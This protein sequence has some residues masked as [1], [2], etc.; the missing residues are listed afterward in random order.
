MNKIPIIWYFIIR[1]SLLNLY[2]DLKI[3]VF[4]SD[5]MFYFILENIEIIKLVFIV[6]GAL[7]VVYNFYIKRDRYP[8]YEFDLDAKLIDRNIDSWLIEFIATIENKGQVRQNILTKTLTVNIRY[9]TEEDMKKGLNNLTKIPIKKDGR[10]V[11]MEDYFVLNF[12]HKVTMDGFGNGRIYWL[13]IHWKYVYIDAQTK[14]NI[15]LP[16]AVPVEAKH[17]LVTSRFKYKDSQSDFHSVQKVF[18][19]DDLCQKV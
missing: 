5:P 10:A 11:D 17:L 16:L 13:P 9:I 8:K 4:F 7:W 15:R 14:Q 19:I 18:R 6:I 12:P 2:S 1:G 3:F